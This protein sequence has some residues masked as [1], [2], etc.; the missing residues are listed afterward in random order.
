[1]K[2]SL[3]M[4]LATAGKPIFDLL[5]N[6]LGKFN[7]LLGSPALLGFANTLATNVAGAITFVIG[8]F[9]TI[10]GRASEAFGGIVAVVKNVVGGNF[11]AAFLGV[12]DII[13]AVF[14]Q[15]AMAPVCVVLSAL[16]W[17][18]SGRFGMAL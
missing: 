7:E 10:A 14:G 5:S 8:L 11:Q 3:N 16:L 13:G 12:M 15:G 17:A 9:G 2:D 1:M 6:G 4:V 18:T